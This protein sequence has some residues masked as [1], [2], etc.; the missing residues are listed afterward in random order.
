L[1]RNETLLFT[2]V[3]ILVDTRG[4]HAWRVCTFDALTVDGRWTV[5]LR[6]PTTPAVDSPIDSP[7]HTR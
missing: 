4:R 5:S 3:D 6:A 1:S 2:P 7:L